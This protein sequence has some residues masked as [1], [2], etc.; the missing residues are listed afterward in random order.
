MILGI[1]LLLHINNFVMSISILLKI[2]TGEISGVKNHNF[3]LFVGVV[4]VFS[5]EQVPTKGISI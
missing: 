1:C 3:Y 2:L 4:S 5:V